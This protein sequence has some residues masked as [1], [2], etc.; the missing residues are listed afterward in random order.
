MS[1]EQT[2]MLKGIAI[3]MMLFLHLFMNPGFADK[4]EPLLWIGD[5]PFAT[6]L[7]RACGPVGFFLLCSGYGMSYLYHRGRLTFAGQWH[8][9]LKLY[10]NYWLILLIFVPICSIVVPETFPGTVTTAIENVTGWNTDVYNHPAWFILPYA[11]ISLT[12]PWLF[13]IVSRIGM[14]MSIVVSFVLSYLSMYVISRYIAPAGLHHAWYSIFITY[15][16]L[17][18]PFMLGAYVNYRKERG[19]TLTIP[20]L[21]R[22]QPLVILL[23][24]C[25]FALHCFTDWAALDIF[26]VAAFLFLFLNIS[27]TGLVHKILLELGRKSMVMWLTHAFFYCFL[28]PEFI[29]GFR[30]PLLIFVALVVVSYL[31]AVVVMWLSD[32]T[33][34]RLPL[35]KH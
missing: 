13:R 21:Q 10:L 7:A 34:G 32:K 6:I 3:L 1:K 5:I 24:L 29:Y 19:L 31:S 33:I 2:T 23:L 4:C 17:L 9:V 8:R 26:F 15:F 30:Y 20:F 12:S 27:I 28:I 11:L 16:D 18:L 22:H 25:W 35:L 14:L